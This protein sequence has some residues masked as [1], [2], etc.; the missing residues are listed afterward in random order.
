MT[1]IPGRRRVAWLVRLVGFWPALAALVMQLVIASIVVP[2]TAPEGG[3][4]PLVGGAVHALH[5]HVHHAATS[6]GKGEHGPR[7]PC[8]AFCPLCQAFVHATPLLLPAGVVEIVR[9]GVMVARA[10]PPPSAPVPP[11]CVAAAAWPRG[12][13]PVV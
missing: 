4:T 12:P 6:P 3:A 11:T 13:P 9:P 10:A 2:M 5:H 8:C 1:R 7:T